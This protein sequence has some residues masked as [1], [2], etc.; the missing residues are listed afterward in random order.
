[1]KKI[2]F[3]LLSILLLQS[4]AMM[5]ADNVFLHEFKTTN[6]LIPFDYFTNADF[7]PAIME[8]I[9]E[10]NQEIA[11]IVNQRS[12]PTFE[13]TIV[14]LERSGQ[15]LNRTLYVFYAMLSS[16]A[17]DE[18]MAISQ[19]MSP[20]L[21]QHGANITLN[22]QLW[23]R[24]KYVYDNR[25]KLALD[26]EDSMLL[27]N[28]YES[29][30]NSG[31]N[32]QGDDRET[33]RRLTTELSNLTL[34]FGQNAL[35]AMNSNELWL[36]ADDLDG[37]P[38]NLI[39]AA[40]LAAEEKG[41]TDAYLFTT[42]APSYR[43]FLQYSARRDLR[44]K[45]YRM[46]NTM[47]TEGEYSNIENIKQ[48][49]LKRMQLAHLMGYKT[50]AEYKQKH[51]MA[52]KPENV[53]NLLDQL[54]DAYL[55]V[56]DEE[57]ESLT[58]FASELEGE[59]I[60]L[61]AWDYSYY[62]NK[63]KDS[64]YSI[65]DEMLRPYF[66]LNNVIKGVFGLATRLYGLHFTQNY[67]AQ[68]L[69]PDVKVYNVTDDNG[70]YVVRG[71]RNTSINITG[72]NPTIYLE[73]AN[74]SAPTPIRIT[75]NSTATICVTGGNSAVTSTSGTGM[76]VEK[77]S[78]LIIT[79]ESTDNVITVRGKNN[80]SNDYPGIGGNESGDCG[81]IRYRRKRIGRL[82]DNPHRECNRSCVWRRNI[83]LCAGN[84][85]VAKLFLRGHH[86]R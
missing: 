26:R 86:H 47:C 16:N 36:T 80:S 31:A 75:G 5:R 71:T 20:I 7:E 69:T 39:D 15:T 24:I 37:L 57:L 65:N 85:T 25:D 58:K 19:K 14:A 29:F 11:S 13:N 56:M 2:L 6:G 10:Q 30:V 50:F 83:R 82:R 60:T 48:I 67:D 45:L 59:P 23:E 3:I 72:D 4:T 27:E 9:K 49:T 73:N 62:S 28:T 43:P 53:Y 8:G 81:T 78:T 79:S 22:Q 32:L 84:R 46:Y 42:Q 61:Q 21:S 74:I 54:R 51:T 76:I 41:R 55:P 64:L 1:M 17:D 66:E 12:M 33:Y 63:Q 18:L 34:A 52:G 35:K 38:Q 68:V 70:N 77:G 44:E 40:K